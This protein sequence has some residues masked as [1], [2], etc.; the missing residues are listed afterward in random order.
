MRFM[1]QIFRLLASHM[2]ISEA[3]VWNSLNAW[4]EKM[5]GCLPYDGAG[6]DLEFQVGSRGFLQG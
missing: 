6:R 2:S 5:N 3:R 1:R 4:A